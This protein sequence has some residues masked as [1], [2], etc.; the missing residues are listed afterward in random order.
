MKLGE[1]LDLLKIEITSGVRR[2]ESLRT[3]GEKDSSVQKKKEI[4]FGNSGQVCSF[5]FPVLIFLPL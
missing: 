4:W 2:N 3:E 5:S 1:R